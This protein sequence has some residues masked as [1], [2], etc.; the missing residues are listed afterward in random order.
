VGWIVPKEYVVIDVDNKLD[1]KYIF[2]ILNDEKVKFSYM[3]GRKGGHFIFKNNRDIGN[4]SKFVTSIGIVIDTRA[5]EKGYI[6]LPEN[7][8]DRS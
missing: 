5:Q 3:T 6:I 1:A 2:K 7:D 8:T 4:G